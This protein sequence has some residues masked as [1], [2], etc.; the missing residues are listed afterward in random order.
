MTKKSK[1]DQPFIELGTKTDDIDVRISHRIIHLFSEGLY[2]SPNKA[3]E[4][5]VSNSF[6][7]G[8]RNVHLIISPDLTS[9]NSTIV[10]LDDGE[11]MDLDGLKNHWVIGRSTRRNETAQDRHPIGKFGIGKLSTY[12]LAD[13]L[14]HISKT[15]GKYFATTMDYIKL[16]P[17][18]G[19]DIQSDEVGIFNDDKLSIPARKLSEDEACE[20][21]KPW[22]DGE[23]LGYSALKLFGDDASESWTVAI[24]SKLTEMGKKVQRGRLGWILRTAMPLRDDFK[25]YFDGQLIEPSKVDYP[26]IQ[27]WVIGK[28]II[29][30]TLG[31]PCPD[32][33]E[34]TEDI[35][36][37]N[38][39]I[40]R[41]GLSHE[42]L[43]RITGYI[44]LYQD[45]LS[46]KS[47]EIERSNGFFVYV[48]GRMINTEDP[49]FGIERNLLR[50]GTFSRF[51]MI[52]HIDSLDRAL[53]SSR[54]S[55][56]QGELYQ[57]AKDFMH[58]A[59]NLTRNRLV[60]WE[61]AQTPGAILSKRISA[62]PGSLTRV[63][64]VVLAEKII[65]GK[66]SPLYTRLPYDLSETSEQDFLKKLKE[67][68]DVKDGFFNTS[69]LVALDA[70]DGLVVYDIYN[71][72]L[73]INSSH[74]FVASFLDLFSKPKTSLPLEMLAMTEVLVEAHLY[75]MSIKENIIRDILRRR[76]ELLRQFVKTSAQRTAGMI[77][78]ALIDAKDNPDK[79]EEEMRASFE[80]IGF[81]NVIRIGRKGKPDGTAEAYL[82]ASEDGIPQRYKVGLEAKS[83]GI[84][85]AH[86]LGVSGISRHMRDF[87]CDHHIVAGNG[88]ATSNGE[89]SASVDE[90]N[91]H[92]EK[93]KKTITLIHIDDLARLVRLVPVKRIGLKRLRS[94][95]QECITPEQ[96]K[97]W[98][99][100]IELETQDQG[101][102]REILETI[103]ERADKRPDEPIE[104]SSVVT[105]LEYRDPPIKISKQDLIEYCKA[106]QVMARGV[107]YAGDN[108][109]EIERRPDLVLNDIRE[110]INAEYPESEKRGFVL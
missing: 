33:L 66:I 8:A 79:L 38:D 23:R 6:D 93:T 29:E 1:N 64:L 27:K 36:K 101:P 87:N 13:Q 77:A 63:P 106:M 67:S 73:Q 107:V 74:P 42:T 83:G 58:A 94:L 76:D 30:D 10:V 110:S 49:G 41:Y 60:E 22:L 34:P 24:L 95:F 91:E 14:T 9:P 16:G 82:A 100:G 55:L 69:E 35:N 61:K 43:G 26:L 19:G 70:K 89:D 98:V 78:L 50:H 40:H 32:G 99:D 54:E 47:D 90:I 15:S 4:E 72:K 48:R 46:G 84:V 56:Q 108:T 59:F 85:S 104:Y 7:A 5:L 20:A 21:L 25:L 65:E 71:R 86:R 17:R 37:D 44:E 96:S 12:V 97:E 57:I 103:W 62:A 88:F 68:V 39:S 28:D 80:A 53:R 31:K 45:E 105:A 11:G 81:T 109:V 75:Q 51:R 3:L 2:S 92:K 102:Y 18:S 52:V